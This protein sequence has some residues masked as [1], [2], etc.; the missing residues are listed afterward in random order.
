MGKDL[1]S[2][3]R[4]QSHPEEPSHLTSLILRKQCKVYSPKVSHSM[5]KSFSQASIYLIRLFTQCLDLHDFIT[6][7]IPKLQVK[8]FFATELSGVLQHIKQSTKGTIFVPTEISDS[9]AMPNDEITVTFRNSA[10][11]KNFPLE[12]WFTK[13][14][15]QLCAK[16]QVRTMNYSRQAR[17]VKT[18]SDGLQRE[19]MQL[20]Q[21]Q[22]LN[23]IGG[24]QSGETSFEAIFFKMDNPEVQQ[25]F[26]RNLTCE[27]WGADEEQLQQIE[28]CIQD[29]HLD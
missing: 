6:V 1:L 25:F 2:S 14:I 17:E 13:D 19:L 27:Q 18:I 11:V 12:G 29:I 4:G 9:I 21:A 15:T 23:L 28:K 7:T 26:M 22:G 8:D 20:S 3:L 16:F 10:N 5:K 24:Y